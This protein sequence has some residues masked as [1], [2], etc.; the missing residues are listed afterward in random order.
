MPTYNLQFVCVSVAVF[1]YRSCVFS[2]LPI[3]DI[4]GEIT[5]AGFQK[6]TPI[7]VI[8]PRRACAARVTVIVL[9]VCMYVDDYSRTVGNKTAYKRYH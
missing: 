7:Q 9:S 4:L 6:P 2:A 8:N 5:K 3:A 1:D